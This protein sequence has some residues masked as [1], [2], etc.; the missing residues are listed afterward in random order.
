MSASNLPDWPGAETVYARA[1][2]INTELCRRS[3]AAFLSR[4]RTRFNRAGLLASRFV[5]PVRD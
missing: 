4:R 1:Q 2:K 5:A 3:H